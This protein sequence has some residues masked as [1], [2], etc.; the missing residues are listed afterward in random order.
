[1]AAQ[2]ERIL[3]HAARRFDPPALSRIGERMLA[4]LDPDG[5]A[6]SEEPETLRELRVRTGSDGT[7]SMTGHLDP[8]AAPGYWRSWARSTATVP[9]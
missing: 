5:I 4:H 9:Q 2:A 1:M 6:P 3:A 8:K 7:V